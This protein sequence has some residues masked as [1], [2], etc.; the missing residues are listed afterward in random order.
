MNTKKVVEELKKE[1]PGKKIVL[2]DKNNPTEIICEIDPASE[3]SDHSTVISVIN[4]TLPHYHKTTAEI[5]SVLKGELNL[6]L[7]KEKIHLNQDEFRVIPPGVVHFGEGKETW[8][9]C[10]SEPGWNQEDH[11]LVK[12][13]EPLFA[14]SFHSVRLLVEKFESCFEFYKDIL[15][16]ELLYGEK[17]KNYAEFDAGMVRIALYQK[18]LMQK[19]LGNQVKLIASNGTNAV[20]SFEVKDLKQTYA[21]LKDKKVKLIKEPE[22]YPDLQT[23]A[24]YVTDPDGNI[25]E[26][27]STI[28]SGFPSTCRGLH[29]T[30]RGA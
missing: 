6:Y 22:K 25:I 18:E 27:R 8:V 5:Y 12:E 3:H 20:L 2:N 10:Y 14:A 7:D 29:S 23:N 24:F 9:L 13:K 30:C 4:K 1:Y 19:V 17:N 15:G 21:F 26:I 11:F 16:F 28:T